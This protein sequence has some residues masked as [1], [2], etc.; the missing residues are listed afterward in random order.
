MVQ[1][2]TILLLREVKMLQ[3]IVLKE[4]GGVFVES[5]EVRALE[6]INSRVEVRSSWEE[7]RRKKY[8]KSA[9]RTYQG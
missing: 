6:G 1:C 9:C 5:N 8:T 7:V 4:K 3:I 2:S